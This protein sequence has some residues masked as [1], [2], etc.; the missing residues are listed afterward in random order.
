MKKAVGVFMI[1]TGVLVLTIQAISL[2]NGGLPLGEIGSYSFFIH[3]LAELASGLIMVFVGIPL[4]RN[5]SHSLKSA[6]YAMGMFIYSVLQ[7]SG[8][9]LQ[10]GDFLLAALYVGLLG[11]G[12]TA[13][14]T[15]MRTD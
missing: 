13:V 10:R 4:A 1:V 3:V 9:S 14:R 7:G 11:L 2:R 5:Q 15:L 8:T 12:L 6:T